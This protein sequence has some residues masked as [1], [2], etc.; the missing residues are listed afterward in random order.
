MMASNRLVSLDVL[1]GITISFMI[2][3]NTPGSW[4][5]VYPPLRHAEWHGC[6]PTDLVFPFFLFIVG[7]SVWFSFAKYKTKIS[8]PVVL[9]I[10][11]RTLIIFLLGFLLNLFPFFDFEKVRIMGVLQRIALAYGAGAILCLTFKRKPLILVLCLILLGYWGVLYFGAETN[12]YSLQKNVVRTFDLF[13][14]GEQHIYKGFGVPFDPEGLLSAIPAVG[15]VIIGYLIGQVISEALTLMSKIKTL[16]LLGF[17]LVLLGGVWNVVFPINKALW[18]SSYVLFTAG[19]ATLLLAALIY[20]IDLKGFNTW[21]KPFIHFGTNPLFI[22]VFSGLYVKT[23]S[24]LIQVPVDTSGDKI[25]GYT[26]LFEHVFAV[27]AGPM[28]GSLLFA[29]THIV[30]FWF[31]CYLLYKNKIFVKI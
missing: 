13:V 10:L 20:I 1:R 14:L 8:K 18:T 22:F 21:S 24:Y 29:L 31:I 2:L 7:V 9:K 26:Y 23:I 11:K 4:S 6:T 25:S 15:T 28:N 19:L 12:P 17:V 30:M 3:V 27:V 16:S 5:F